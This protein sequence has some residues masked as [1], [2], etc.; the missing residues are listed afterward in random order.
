MLWHGWEVGDVAFDDMKRQSTA[1]A[2]P[3]PCPVVPAD[4][5]KLPFLLQMHY[6]TRIA[7]Q[8]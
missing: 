7:E 1:R 2:Y 5:S 6:L 3:D 8:F 4:N